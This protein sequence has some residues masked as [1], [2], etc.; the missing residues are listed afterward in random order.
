[1]GPTPNSDPPVWVIGIGHP[2]GGDDGVG[3]ALVRRLLQESPPPEIRCCILSS[4]LHLLSLPPARRWI[5]ID[6]LGPPFPPGRVYLLTPQWIRAHGRISRSLACH[7]VTLQE[8]LSLLPYRPEPAPE[9]ILIL[10]IG[11]PVPSNPGLS[12]SPPVLA[13]LSRALTWVRRLSR[14]P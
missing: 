1:M 4:P 2:Y 10:G 14:L 13:G 3:P 9:E 7:G 6:A 8:A 5:L 11:V 12:F